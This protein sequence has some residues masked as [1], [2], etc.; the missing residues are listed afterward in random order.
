MGYEDE[1]LENPD[2]IREKYHGECLSQSEI[3]D[4]IGC[5]RSPIR[6]KMEEYGIDRRSDGIKP[7]KERFWGRVEKKG[8]GCWVWQGSTKN[9]YPEIVVDG[10]TRYGHRL[11][12]EL[13]TGDKPGDKQVNHHCDNQ[14]CVNID[15]MYLGTQADNVADQVERGLMARGEDRNTSTLTADG[16]REIRKKYDSGDYLQ[17][18]LANEYDTTRGN[19]GSIVR[20]DTWD[21]ID[22]G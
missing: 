7:L 15:H 20:R 17:K 1:R 9:D 12:Y 3:A 11:A 21:H 22:N 10:R 4:I 13:Q 14:L 2:W 18:E 6:K 5:S 8:S 16:V 19:I